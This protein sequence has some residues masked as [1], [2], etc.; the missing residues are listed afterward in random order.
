MRRLASFLK[1]KLS[2]LERLWLGL[3]VVV[4]FSYWPNLHFGQD[5]TMNYE[6]SVALI[7]CL[8]LALV[9]LPSV[10]RDRQKL[11]RNHQ[12]WLVGSLVVYAGVTVLWSLNTTRGFLT[13]GIIGILFLIFLGFV[14]Q[15]RQ[16]AKLA[17]RLIKLIVGGAVAMGIL[18][19]IQFLVGIWSSS[20]TTLLCAGCVSGQFGWPRPN[21]FTIEPQFFG[22]L[23]LLPLLIVTNRVFL[24][25]ANWRW[26]GLVGFLQFSLFLTMSRGAIY[27]YFVGVVILTMINYRQI[28]QIGSL[29]LV[30][31]SALLI[32]FFAQ[33]LAVIVSPTVSETFTGAV[34]KSLNQL[35]LGVVDLRPETKQ[36]ITET[37]TS[38]K[39]EPAFDGYVEESTNI[40]L[41]RTEMALEAWQKDLPTMLFGAGLGSAG[42]AVHQAYP[43]EIGAREIVQN[44][45]AERLLERGL[46]GL[47]LFVVALVW[48][49]Y[50]LRPRW[51]VAIVAAYMFQWLFFSGYPN[52][53]HI[54]LGLLLLSTWPLPSAKNS[55]N[56]PQYN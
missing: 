12:V 11:I 4:W 16:L 48:L 46:I 29:I 35:S 45:Y 20:D 32:S 28:R 38:Q 37:D 31:L 19:I 52:A 50:R 25:K 53:L 42:L 7:Y 49:I 36:T 33:G 23:L 43:E 34:T 10:W 40:R 1:P 51:L 41:G 6:A 54:Y 30:S 22:N 24:K 17:P 14:A 39:E 44:E 15:R 21:V 5:G 3:P 18:A 2:L 8:V 47:G 13:A 9:G 27:A 26:L 55:T 56:S